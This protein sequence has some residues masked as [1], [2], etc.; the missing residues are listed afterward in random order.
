VIGEGVRLVTLVGTAGVGKTRLALEAGAALLDGFPGG[1]HLVEL[2]ALEDADGVPGAI[3]GAIGVEPEE[4]R[5][6]ADVLA[7]ALADVRSLLVLDNFEHVRPAGPAVASLL[8]RCPNLHVLATSRSALRLRGERPFAVEPLTLPTAAA[9]PE[10]IAAS[11][12]VRLLLERAR[13][14][15]PELGVTDENAGALADICRRLDGLPL[16]IEL[17]AP[18]LAALGA[19]ELRQ[20]LD[21]VLPLLTA[22]ARDLPARQQTLRAAIAWS[23]GFLGERE[24]ILLGR[25]GVFAGGCTSAAAALVCEVDDLDH[26]LGL[27]VEAS[28]VRP[29]PAVGGDRFELLV[30]IEE[31][32]RDLLE[33]DDEA[34]ATHARHAGYFLTLA[35]EAAPE[36]TGSGQMRWIELLDA[37]RANLRRAV[38][39]AAER[40]EHELVARLVTSLWR[41]WERRGAAAEARAWIE[42]ALAAGDLSLTVRARALGSQARFM[43]R[44]G[45]YAASGRLW[46]ESLELCRRIGDRAGESAALAALSWWSSQV[47]GRL[48]EAVGL[49]GEAVAVARQLG[50]PVLRWEAANVLGVALLVSGERERAEPLFEECLALARE[51]GDEHGTCSSLGNLAHVAQARGRY[52]RASELGEEALELARALLDDWLLV[53]LLGFLAEVALVAD[54]RER[55]AEQLAEAYAAGRR[56]GEGPMVGGVLESVARMASE[57][58]PAEAARLAGAAA[59]LLE[60]AG[61]HVDGVGEP[62]WRA[63]L[64]ERL[65]RDFG[66]EV[67]AGE[68]AS[69]DA[70]ESLVRRLTAQPPSARPGEAACRS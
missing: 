18:R 62:P 56:L 16:A 1:V 44:K 10:E 17:A 33:H 5:P 25:L 69:D 64:A 37:E 31:L 43:G 22:G 3:A 61:V 29:R 39:W 23:V 42:P 14:G 40:G 53:H 11:P 48:H 50:D 2:A 7:E 38:G 4:A 12:A 8:E 21:P 26:G 45:D 70:I 54:D 52:R 51:R 68:Q 46:R 36:L 57:R 49:G 20:R 34:E 32:A 24:R 6:L 66:Q 60:T 47:A 30:T 27:L 63:A 41:F 28:L 13:A 15:R 19:E 59:R 35:E 55:A 9:S 67:A 65:G 58:H